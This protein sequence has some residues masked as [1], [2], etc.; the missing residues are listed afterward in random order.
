MA[1][2]NLLSIAK[3]LQTTI[4]SISVAGGYNYDVASDSVTLDPTVNLFTGVAVTELPLFVIQLGVEEDPE[5]HPAD[6]LVEEVP[7]DIF[8]A[9]DIVDRLDPTEKLELY[10]KLVGDLETVLAV[11]P[12]RGGFATETRIVRKSMFPQMGG[13][14]VIAVIE[15]RC[16]VY[17]TFGAP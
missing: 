16:R 12:T 15:T 1:D 3:N 4:R 5:R 7:F 2:T 14:R 13:A 6:Q 9:H 8:A 10:S 11:D 17:R